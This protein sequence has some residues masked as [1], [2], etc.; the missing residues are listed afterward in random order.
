[1]HTVSLIILV[2]LLLLAAY[3]DICE[4]RISNKLI[5]LGLIAGISVN[6]IL[7][8]EI[9]GLGFQLSI[10][11]ASVGLLI[12]LPMYFIRAMGA[13]DI[14]LMAMVG[15]FV[16]PMPMV[17]ITLFISM[18]GGL[19]ALIVLFSKSKLAKFIHSY[20]FMLF[21]NQLSTTVGNLDTIST[22]KVFSKTKARLP[23][24]VAI[25]AGTFFYLFI[26]S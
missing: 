3:R 21:R 15:T 17:Q 20:K 4:Y 5:L 24:G 23:Y 19:L 1:M 26:N 12:F 8:Q 10:A 6:V 13:G 25:A 16:G 7:P 22:S 9:G 11:G 2:G 14:K 18:A